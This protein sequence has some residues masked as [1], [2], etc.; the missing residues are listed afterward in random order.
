M[1]VRTGSL[2]TIPS[3]FAWALVAGQAAPGAEK[4]SE[5]SARQLFFVA[6]P[7]A[8]P[9]T[10]P[11][12]AAPPRK[13]A[14]KAPEVAS[15]P[16]VTPPATP[17]LGLR[18]SI[19]QPRGGKLEDVAVDKEFRSREYFGVSLR[20]N[21]DA[22]LYVVVQGSAG[23]WDVLFPYPGE[24]NRVVAGQDVLIPPKCSPN[25]QAECFAFDDDPGTERMFVVLSSKPETDLDRLINSVRSRGAGAVAPARAGG[26]ATLASASLPGS[27]VN[28]LREQMQLASR[29]IIRETVRRAPNSAEGENAMYIVASSE[30]PQS[31]VIVDIVLKHR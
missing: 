19:L 16:A 23:N 29:G 11:A 20:S 14:P 7:V 12:K 1:F 4:T 5:L 27:E 26:T 21:E 28:K 15:E 17:R 24:R 30:S 13:S 10:P 8:K 18:Y 9:T 2:L 6:K 31:R 3:L 22:F 25:S